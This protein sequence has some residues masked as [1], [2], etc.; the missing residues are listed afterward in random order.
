LQAK[1]ELSGSIADDDLILTVENNTTARLVVAGDG[2]VGI[3]TTSPST[4]PLEVASGAVRGF[5]AY[6]NSASRSVLKDR[7]EDVNVLSGIQDMAIYEWQYKDE[8]A[9]TNNDYTRHLYPFADYFFDTFG[10]GASENQISGID[11]A[12]VALRGVQ[13]VI[14]VLDVVNAPTTTPTLVVNESG[15]ATFSGS[16]IAT[17]FI[18]TGADIAEKYPSLEELEVG[19]LVMADPNN[20]GY[21]V[22]TT[23]ESD[24]NILGIVSGEPGLLMG[25][26]VDN[27]YP[28]AML[29]RVPVKISN[30]NGNIY[31]G[32]TLTPAPIP[33]FAM[34]LQTGTEGIVIGTALE[35]FEE[36]SGQV[37]MYVNPDYKTNYIDN[38]LVMIGDGQIMEGAEISDLKLAVI[39]T[40]GKIAT[41]ALPTHVAMLQGD[42]QT[43]ENNIVFGEDSESTSLVVFNSRIASN[44]EFEADGIYDIGSSDNSLANLYSDN[45]YSDKLVIKSDNDN[46]QDI[47]ISDYGFY[48]TASSGPAYFGSNVIIGDNDTLE[49]ALVEFPEFVLDGSDLLVMDDLGVAGDL[50]VQGNLRIAGVMEFGGN[51]IAHYFTVQNTSTSTIESGTLVTVSTSTT[52]EAII[53]EYAN[54][55]NILGVVATSSTLRFN[56]Q[57]MATSSLPIVT[58]GR[59]Q[60]KVTTE[61]GSINRGDMLTSA[62]TPG[63]AMLA[64]KP[65][66]G[67]IGM[68]LASLEEGEG[69]I[70]ILVELGTYFEPIAQKIKVASQGGDFKTITQALESINDNTAQNRY[71]IEVGSGF[72]EESITLKQYVDVVGQGQGQTIIS[73]DNS[74]VVNID[75]NSRLEAMT[76]K[77]T[78]TSTDPVLI[79]INGLG[80]TTR[81]ILT[82]LNLDADTDYPAIGLSVIGSAS[83]VSLTNSIFSY[84]FYQAISQL[85]STTL[86][87]MN[88]DLTEVSG[89]AIVAQNGIIKSFNNQ[90]DGMLG[91]YYVSSLAYIE[92]SGDYYDQV[93]NFGIFL[94]VT[95]RHK[96]PHEYIDYGWLVSN[97]AASSTL[98]VNIGSGSGFISGVKVNTAAINNIGMFASSTNY[99]FMTEYGDIT[100]ATSTSNI[101]TSTSVVLIAQVQTNLSGITDIINERT[102]EIVVAKEGGQYRTINE[103]LESIT[104]N[105]LGNR[106]TLLVKPGIYNEQVSLKPYVDIIGAGQGLTTIMSLNKPVII[107]STEVLNNATSTEIGDVKVKDITLSMSGDVLGQAVVSA[108]TTNLTL[109]D[110]EVK[111]S[112]S[113]GIFGDGVKVTGD[114]SIIL[115]DIN[116]NDVAYGVTHEYLSDNS[117]TSTIDIMYSSIAS[118]VNDIRTV[119]I[120]VETGEECNEDTVFDVNNTLNNIT[121]SYN[122]LTGS[123]KSFSVALNTVISSAHDTYLSYEG[124][125]TFKQND[126][127]RNQVGGSLFNIQNAGLDLFGINASG[128]VS[129]N[130]QNTTGDSF[131][132]TSATS[133]STLRVVNSNGGTALT[134]VGDLV[135]TSATSTIPVSLSSGGGQLNIGKPGD[136]IN[137]NLDGVIYNFK[138]NVRRNTLSVYLD[139]PSIGDRVWGS[140]TQSWSPS[141]NVT[142]KA[143]KVQYQCTEG[144]LQMAL[145]DKNGNVIKQINGYTCSGYSNVVEE[146]EYYLTSDNGMYLEVQAS[147]EAITNVTV[148]I[149]YVYDNE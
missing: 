8:I 107:S 124:T 139:S 53:S 37:S 13:D 35:T 104:S 56:A 9:L 91:D 122:I 113:N 65:G 80:T 15:D 101:S 119:C 66:A 14:T 29:G 103:A 126:Y 87:I 23:G 86:V 143:I 110:V 148:T 19:D 71:I 75:T 135:I 11:V 125:G 60:V 10:L 90:I 26:D 39:S 62:H 5:G 92:S 72:Y 95:N 77:S 82:N 24:N 84:N 120:D 123:G 137:L 34:K 85:A 131:T 52:S 67:V 44:L 93:T 6:I 121:S 28:V 43:F 96:I 54:A 58:S 3:G 116:I 32:D 51:G 57:D 36:V 38:A 136:T 33:G 55:T 83:K 99:I 88:N 46:L 73:S 41:S 133:S 127:F 111:W 42:T 114:S 81:P 94:D 134:V 25:N 140:G 45:I 18:S 69:T 59:T 4:H 22:K 20:S 97:N 76:I 138:E 70:S 112:G 149:E 144:L 21:I 145:K 79:G 12:G 78:S 89:T 61:N 49:V 147:S 142:I 102:N 106:W 132:I 7:W 129:V 146:L 74:P 48:L 63:Y 50:Y 130:P 105:T 31:P 128:T 27:G 117:A 17:D 108:S 64:T 47:N 40:P 118:V 98:T 100:V 16:V 1:N 68:A 115:K 30:V 2:K 141:E 109:E